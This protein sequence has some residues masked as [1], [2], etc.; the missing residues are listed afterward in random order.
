MSTFQSGDLV[1]VSRRTG[2]WVV[3]EQDAGSLPV[4]R[5]DLVQV[6]AGRQ[7]SLIAGD[8]DMNLFL[9]LALS[10]GSIVR[11]RHMHAEVLSSTAS[12]VRL[13][14]DERVDVPGGG[15]LQHVDSEVDVPFWRIVLD[16]V[17]TLTH[18]AMQ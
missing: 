17:S 6:D 18:E 8:G 7:T 11:Y 9:R 10:A 15:H 1:T 16:N 12:N 13:Q 4:V 3:R 14:F 5:W 2:V